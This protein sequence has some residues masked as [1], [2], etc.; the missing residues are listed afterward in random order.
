MMWS[1]TSTANMVSPSL[2][3]VVADAVAQGTGNRPGLH[4]SERAAPVK[5]LSPLISVSRTG[6][7]PAAA[8]PWPCASHGSSA[9]LRAAGRLPTCEL[10]ETQAPAVECPAERRRRRVADPCQLPSTTQASVPAHAMAVARPCAVADRCRDDVAV[11]RRRFG[12]GETAADASGQRRA[13]FRIHVDERDLGTRQSTGEIARERADKA[14]TD[15]GDTVAGAR[16]AVPEQVQC[17]LHV[18]GQ[19][20]APG[21]D[22]RWQ[23][24]QLGFRAGGSAPGAG[25]ERTPRR[26]AIDPSTTRPTAQ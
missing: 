15:H 20:R 23:G 17:R 16:A 4:R 6:D 8:A 18:G 19:H 1:R 12:Q 11:P 3:V 2:R 24:S 13:V 9:G 10:D 5:R 7:R 25:A 22:V 21:G 26:P 14:R